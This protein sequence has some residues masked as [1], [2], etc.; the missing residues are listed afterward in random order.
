M[1]S[2]EA[3]YFAWDAWCNYCPDDVRTGCSVFH[4]VPFFQTCNKVQKGNLLSVSGESGVE[5]SD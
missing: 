1:Y 4:R 3:N 5:L 2:V